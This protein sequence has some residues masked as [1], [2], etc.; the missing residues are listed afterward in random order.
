[1]KLILGSRSKWRADILKRMGY[2]F[3]VMAADI[4]EK[5]IRFGDPRQLALALA[6]AKADVLLPQIKEEAILVTSD[7]VDIC[8]G[9][10]REKPKDKEEAKEFLRSYNEYPV[11]T[12]T[13]VVAVNTASQKRKEGV[14]IA[15]VYFNHLSEEKINE[16]VASGCVFSCAGGYC[17]NDPAFKGCIE[18]VEG[19]VDSVAGLPPTLTGRLIDEVK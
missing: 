12:V 2:D 3:A 13:A 17:I 14:D 5:A 11:E 9:E 16:L 15:K 8:N 1:M 4:D 18:R 19:E 10:I 7:Q 6:R